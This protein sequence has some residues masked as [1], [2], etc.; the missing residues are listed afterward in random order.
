MKKFKKVV[1]LVIIF[2][3]CFG[4]L[5]GCGKKEDVQVGT[6]DITNTEQ[7]KDNKE[8]TVQMDK[9]Q[10]FRYSDKSDI[11]GLN[12]MLNTT[13]PDNGVHDF[14]IETLVAEVTDEDGN[15]IMKP[16]AAK[17]W[18][19]SD[20][21]TVYTFNIRE[22]AVWNDGVPVTANDFL[23]TFRTMATPEVGSTNAWLFDGIIVNFAESLY[24]DGK[25]PAYNKK[26]EDIGVKVIDDKT[27]EF[28]LVKPY[29]YFL[30]LLEGAKPVRQDKYEEW[31]TEYGS[32]IDKVV[33]NGP[34][35][36]ESWDPNVQ[37]TFVKNDNY[38]GASD[39]KLQK[40]E[41]KV[42]QDPPT[43]AQAL[44][45]G[46]ID[47]VAA[48]DPEW[49]DLISADGRFDMTL[50]PGNSPEFFG[51]NCSNKY[52]KNP[53]I[54]LAFS[55]AFDREKY[56]QDLRNGKAEPL[57]SMMPSVINVG[58][59]PYRDRVNG[60]NE[61][62]KE[63][64]KQYPDPK[65]LLIEGLKEEGFDPDPAK[66][67]ISYVTRGTTEYSKKS[68]EW[69]LQQWKEKL[70]VEIK[71]DMIEWNVMW[72]RVHAGDYD[73]CT[74]GW[75][76]YYNDPNGLLELYEPVNGYFNSDKSGWS[77]PDA[78]KFAE[79]LAKASNSPDN[80]ERAELFV[81]AEK[82]LVGTAVIVPTYTA[83]STF[84]TAKYVKNYHFNSISGVDYTKV[85]IS[86]R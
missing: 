27:I 63:L 22:D 6:G 75:G 48:G 83:S 11:T 5:T 70:G 2:A 84:F 12:P 3:L 66:M 46:D 4:T 37:I 43:A 67:D 8:D 18:K 71:I 23:F 44:I 26:P 9:E 65:A 53:K 28:T 72:D 62:I 40:I 69:L 76:P 51:F 15:T 80:Q 50:T 86:G 35:L 17:N 33:M 81:E 47:V 13:A 38:W 54:R 14:I 36:L 25:D 55:L 29:G 31:G 68:A 74:S 79:I 10:V 34:F 57:Y 77:G 42:I 58:E 19:V 16:A 7:S 60:K 73:I 24:N 85:Y 52:F 1:I 30:D 21:G 61:V 45:S 39:V 41:R 78:D 49:I 32:S 64:L 56:V 82:I 59:I 20:D